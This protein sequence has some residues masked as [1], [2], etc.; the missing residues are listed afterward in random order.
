MPDIKMLKDKITDSGMTVK[1]VAE[2]SGILRETLYNRLK[3]VGEFTASE[4]VS[5]SNVLNLSQ[6]ERDDIF[7]K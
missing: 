2:K 6:T 7:F 5:L 3:G 4:I 1:A